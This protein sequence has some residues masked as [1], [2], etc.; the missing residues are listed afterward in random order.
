MI[1]RARIT[2]TVCTLSDTKVKG[3]NESSFR[4]P[5][6][7][8]YFKTND[9]VPQLGTR[10]EESCWGEQNLWFKKECAGKYMEQIMRHVGV[11]S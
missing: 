11:S 1:P 5:K 4:A 2:H 6:Y 9:V 10:N 3:I 7:Y 8:G